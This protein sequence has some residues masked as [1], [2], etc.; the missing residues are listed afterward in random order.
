MMNLEWV[1]SSPYLS[2]YFLFTPRPDLP[3]HLYNP[4]IKGAFMKYVVVLVS[5]IATT[6]LFANPSE[7]CMDQA[8]A[9]VTKECLKEW[10]DCKLFEVSFESMKP[11]KITYSV[12]MT[13]VG[14]DMTEDFDRS[15]SLDY[16]IESQKI[17]CE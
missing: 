4:Y 5:L 2:T 6:S 12:K 9:K 16:K 1:P 14:Y 13:A 17:I 7:Q 15:V 11:N 8:V 10:R 3:T